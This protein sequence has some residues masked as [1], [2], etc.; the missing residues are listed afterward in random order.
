MLIYN[1][2]DLGLG[3]VCLPPNHPEAVRTPDLCDRFKKF[4]FSRFDLFLLSVLVFWRLVENLMEFNDFC[5]MGG[6][7]PKS[8]DIF[9]EP[10]LYFVLWG[11]HHQRGGGI[12]CL[13]HGFSVFSEYYSPVLFDCLFYFCLSLLSFLHKIHIWHDSQLF[14]E[15]SQISQNL[16]S[17][18]IHPKHPLTF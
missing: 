9:R 13:F 12:F 15:N 3:D 14:A 1:H 16:I 17:H 4:E 7:S 2:Q 11:H 8:S 10:S 6:K 18:K 5:L